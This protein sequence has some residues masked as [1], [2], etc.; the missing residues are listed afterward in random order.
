MVHISMSAAIV[1]FLA[2]AAAPTGL[3]AQRLPSEG[4]CAGAID[5]YQGIVKSDLATGNVERQV[6]DAI[7][8]EL[9]S[10]A[11]ACQAGRDGQAR[12]L[13]AASKERHGYHN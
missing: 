3:A 12:A 10:A 5:S 4:G 9:S 11:A 13:V 7:E 1:V 6:Y 8:R 2:A